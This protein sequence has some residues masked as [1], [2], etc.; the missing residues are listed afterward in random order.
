MQRKIVPNVVQR[1]QVVTVVSGDSVFETAKLMTINNIAAMVVANEQGRIIG[2]VTE[3][4]ITQ[5]ITAEG[6]DGK[7][8]LVKDIMTTN[9]DTLS[10]NDSAGDALELMQTRNYRHLPVT[11]DGQCVAV[12]SIRDLYA[13]VK[14]ALEEDIRETKAFVFGG[15]YG[16]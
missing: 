8:T 13:W 4:D 7:S 9:P 12:V 3:R 2:I 5:R 11:E 16:A 15:R 1:T 6:L 14:K 10:P